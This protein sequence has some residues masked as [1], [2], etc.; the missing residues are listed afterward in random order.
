MII[1]NHQASGGCVPW[2]CLSE[3]GRQLSLRDN[4]QPLWLELDGDW[5]GTLSR[6]DVACVATS[7]SQRGW[8]RHMLQTT[9]LGGSTPGIPALTLAVGSGR[10]RPKTESHTCSI[11]SAK[12]RALFFVL[13]RTWSFV[14][15]KRCAIC[16]LKDGVCDE[17]LVLRCWNSS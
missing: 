13:P 16:G 2:G 3:T 15:W 6:L 12:A 11:S 10:I 14:C 9:R 8:S 5:A 17:D 1:D 7:G 4:H